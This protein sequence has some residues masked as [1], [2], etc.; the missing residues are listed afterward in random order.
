MDKNPTEKQEDPNLIKCAQIYQKLQ[1]VS[2]ASREAAQ[3]LGEQA[4]GIQDLIDENR[5][6][7]ALESVWIEQKRTLENLEIAHRSTLNEVRR[8]HQVEVD[9]IKRELKARMEDSTI[10]YRDLESRASETIRSLKSALIQAQQESKEGSQVSSRREAEQE[11]RINELLARID[12]DAKVSFEKI[13]EI[14]KRHQLEKEQ[15]QFDFQKSRSFLLASNQRLEEIALEK[16]RE[17][18][19]ARKRI[20]ILG[21]DPSRNPEQELRQELLAVRSELSRLENENGK[22]SAELQS[23]S[24]EISLLRDELTQV[25]SECAEARE[26][27]DTASGHAELS[28]NEAALLRANLAR[29]EGVNQYLENENRLLKERGERLEQELKTEKAASIYQLQIAEESLKEAL[30]NA[31]RNSANNDLEEIPFPKLDEL[32]DHVEKE[33]EKAALLLKEGASRIISG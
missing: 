15:L 10:R 17:L 1:M 21:G 23:R 26:Q 16:E 7:R 3:I 33:R 22:Q 4:K 18:E 29:V 9:S 14:E 20:L 25:R 24:F 5:N 28:G 11:S 30:Q 12:A 19:E 8:C 2:A 6:L 32:R 13:T 31:Q 27:L